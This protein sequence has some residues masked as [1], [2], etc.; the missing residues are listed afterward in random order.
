[1]APEEPFDLD[2]ALA[3][4][5]GDK[6]LFHELVNLFVEESTNQINQV[7]AGIANGDAK[8]VERSAHSIKGSASTFAAKRS[9]EA[10]RH[11][12]VL[13]REGKFAELPPALAVLEAELELLKA[14]LKAAPDE[15]VLRL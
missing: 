7:R 15:E 1:M 14:A 5:D 12:E 8:L 2:A 9:A 6:A 13:G 11:V 3:Y 4:M 10:A